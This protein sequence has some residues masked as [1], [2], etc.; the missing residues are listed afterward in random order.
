L[1]LALR[2]RGRLSEAIES[3]QCAIELRPE[4]ADQYNN[5]ADALQEAGR[6]EEAIAAYRRALVLQPA[7]VEVSYN[8]ATA[9]QESGR[10]EEAIEAYRLTLRL[11]PSLAEA[12]MMLGNALGAAGRPEDAINAYHDAIRLRPDYAEAFHNLGLAMFARRRYEEAVAAALRATELRA[13]F[14]EAFRALGCAYE[15]CGRMFE[16]VAMYRKAL[17]LRP[18]YPEAYNSL[19]WNYYQS[20]KLPE[21]IS[22]LETALA[23][24]PEHAEARLSRA[25]L[26]LSQGDFERGLPEYEARWEASKR[27]A[28][29]GFP[30]PVW[31]GG[32]LHGK[33]IL[34]HAEQGL[35]DVIQ[36]CR[37]V[38]LIRARGGRVVVRCWRPLKRL[39][40][41]QL[42]IED[43]CT[44]KEL[45]PPFDT[46]CPI[47]SLPRMFQTRLETIPANVPYLGVDQSLVEWWRQRLAG[48]PPG[49]RV[50]LVWAGDPDHS[51][52]HLRSAALA[53]FAP[54]ASVPGVCFYS[55]QSGPGAEQAL[56]P[57]AG[58]TIRFFDDGVGD[59]ASTAALMQNLALVIAVDTSAGH[60]AGAIGRP[61]WLLL[62]LVPDWR[63]MLGRA[64]TP[65]Y[66]TMRLFRQTRL[67]DWS[68]PV[69]AMVRE[70]RA[71]TRR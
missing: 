36:F 1:G 38:P 39:F 6:L 4:S 62:H 52:D 26:L 71:M 54:L 29:R 60:L 2:Q 20:A 49:L 45:P 9:L 42:D 30:Q 46:H 48:D 18:T 33:T 28:T 41:G 8:L 35:G 27:S 66:P 65:W 50:G 13:D 58:M 51:N 24:R 63:W 19:G 43:V 11:A 34:L 5:L 67:G 22:A 16:A 57:P 17:V 32:D 37:Y 14:P 44:D 56:N 70:L 55:L 25:M 12:H 7:F 21:A 15:R 64:D 40:T 31:D 69:A 10:V 68:A 53:T 59:M 23:Q 47:A 3:Y 61:V